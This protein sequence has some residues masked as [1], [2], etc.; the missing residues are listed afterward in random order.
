MSNLLELPGAKKL[1]AG[2]YPI[3]KVPE[4]SRCDLCVDKEAETLEDPRSCRNLPPCDGFVFIR[5][6]QESRDLYTVEYVK[7]AMRPSEENSDGTD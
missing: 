5:D 1:R 4:L 2:K 6:N 3:L 7:L